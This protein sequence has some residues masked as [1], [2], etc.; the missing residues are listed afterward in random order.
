MRKISLRTC[1]VKISNRS[2]VVDMNVVFVADKSNP[3]KRI[4]Q[5]HFSILLTIL[6]TKKQ[7]QLF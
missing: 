6:T 4:L 2:I 7:E 5:S 3:F 1:W